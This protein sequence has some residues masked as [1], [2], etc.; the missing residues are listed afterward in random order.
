LKKQNEMLSPGRT[1]NAANNKLNEK[2]KR[3]KIF[4]KNVHSKTEL[5][6][7]LLQNTVEQSE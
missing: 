6:Q 1:L 3:D 2:E 4:D 5:Q 7:A